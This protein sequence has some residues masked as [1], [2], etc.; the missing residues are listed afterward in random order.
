MGDYVFYSKTIVNTIGNSLIVETV[1]KG[2]AIAYVETMP[3]TVTGF[4]SKP[5]YHLLLEGDFNFIPPPFCR[6]PWVGVN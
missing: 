5:L 1:K 4:P 6:I 3:L 2:P